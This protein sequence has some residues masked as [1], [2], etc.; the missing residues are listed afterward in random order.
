MASPVTLEGVVRRFPGAPRDAVAELS[1]SL[2][3]GQTLC[4]VGPS[5]CGKSTTLRMIAGLEAPDRGRIRIG[6]RDMTGVPPQAR[7]VAMVFQG[8][9]LYPHLKV[10]DIIGFPLKM[11]R[12]PV[13]DRAR[14][15]GEA[16]EL[17]GISALLDR[18]PDQLSGGERQRV[19]MGRAIVRR[20]EVF[21]FDEPL[22]N[23]DAK[24]R[25]ELRGELRRLLRSLGA[26][27]VY[28]THDQVEA[29][30]LGDQLAVM[31]AG[32]LMQLGTPRAIY[33]APESEFV[34]TFFGSPPMAVCDVERTP[35]GLQVGSWRLPMSAAPAGDEPL[36]VG[37]RAEA[38]C[39][40]DPRGGELGLTG[41]VTHREPL[42]AETELSVSLGD[43]S[44]PS[45]SLR[46]PGFDAPALGDRVSAAV[47]PSALY[48]F[49]RESGERRGGAPRGGSGRAHD[50]S[51]T[52]VQAPDVSATDVSAPDASAG[53]AEGE[54]AASAPGVG[55]A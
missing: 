38:L 10:K 30:T 14:Q 23:L 26:T 7:D 52:D 33:E 44:G 36:R 8:F 34:A 6:E 19:A 11:R 35:D 42:G 32:R 41:R 45:L 24:L 55:D 48:W 49:S 13:A 39:L 37:V 31:R 40:G 20:P 16:A 50:V 27:A 28:V 12:V 5:G 15:V 46:V 4:L 47:D 43:D 29:M 25:G 54:P 9:A 22:S 1:L 2:P 18:T 21:L 53:D 17:L 3:A 51:A